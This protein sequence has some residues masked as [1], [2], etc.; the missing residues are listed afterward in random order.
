MLLDDERTEQAWRHTAWLTAA[1]VNQQRTKEHCLKPD[2]VNYLRLVE[3]ERAKQSETNRGGPRLK[4]S[5]VF[6]FF[7]RGRKPRM[8]PPKSGQE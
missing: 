5:D 6:K 4:M 2:D 3:R 1:I 8:E 7:D